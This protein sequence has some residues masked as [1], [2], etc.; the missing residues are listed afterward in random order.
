VSLR[1]APIV[2]VLLALLAAVAPAAAKTALRLAVGDDFFRILRGWATTRAGENVTTDE[3]VAFAERVAG[4]ELDELFATWLF[5]PSKP[6]G[7]APEA[8]GTSAQAE[9]SQRAAVTAGLA[10]RARAPQR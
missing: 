8:P 9:T 3:F 10:A 6:E 4:E 5:T 1:A 7:I 2:A